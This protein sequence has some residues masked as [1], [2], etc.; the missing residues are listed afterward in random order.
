METMPEV[1]YELRDY[2][3]DDIPTILD[4][5]KSAFAEYQGKLDP[6]SSAERKTI[7]LVKE[8]LQTANAIVVEVEERIVG[9]VFYQNTDEGVYLDRLSVLPDF[10]KQ[11]IATSLMAEVERR[12]RNEFGAEALRLSVRLSL[13]KQQALYKR[14]GFEFLEFGTHEGYPKPT[15]MKMMKRL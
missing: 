11:G 12:A 8:E 10:R 4:V 15:Y 5:I 14:F 1:L 2:V 3:G 9:C 7:E 6:P 13:K